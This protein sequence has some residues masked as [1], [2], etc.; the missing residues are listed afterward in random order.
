MD[1][2]SWTH[3]TLLIDMNVDLKLDTSG[4][5]NPRH[6]AVSCFSYGINELVEKKNR[7]GRVIFGLE[8]PLKIKLS[9][10]N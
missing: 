10:I 5:V 8:L 2:L 4:M 1:L 9:Y 3:I 7:F 6:A